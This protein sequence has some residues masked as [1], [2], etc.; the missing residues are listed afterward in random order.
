MAT[1]GILAPRTRSTGG[2]GSNPPAELKQE[3]FGG[4]LMVRAQSAGAVYEPQTDSVAAPPLEID[5]L[6]HITDPIVPGSLIFQWGGITYIDRSGVLFRAVNTTTNA[7]TA[8]GAV[9]YATGVAT[10]QSYPGGEGGVVNR[11]A[12]LTENGGFSTTALTFRTPGAPLRPASLQITV[13]RADNS[14]IVTGTADLN[15][16][17]T[18]G[19]IIHGEVDI[20]SGIVRLRF[21]TNPDDLTGAS[22]VPVIALLVTYNAVIQTSLP[23]SADLLGL[24]PVRLPAD[25]R[26]PIYRDGDVLVIHHATETPVVPSA[27]QT[28]QLERAYQAAIEV[29]DVNGV[30]MRPDQYTAD[31][32]LGL[33]TW[34]DPVLSED[35]E[36]NPLTPPLTLRDRVEHMTVCTE[37]QISG[38]ISFGSPLPWDLSAGETLVSSAVTWGDLQARVH[39]WFTQA[40]WNQGAP[41]WGDTPIGNSTTAQYNQLNYP[42]EITNS[43]AI[44]G[45]WAII[46]TS[47][48]AFNVVEEK[49]G[50][51]TTGATGM[52]CAPINPA[53]GVPYFIIR[54]LGWG[55]GWAA[56][57]AVRF[58]TDACLGPMWVVRTVISGQGAVDDDQFKLQIRGDAD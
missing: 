16:N 24:D 39:R 31:R 6:P 45:K 41:N 46:F 23:M 57:N 30:P 17:V 19:G 5:L 56:G 11:I 51:I 13:I 12:A 27:G 14:I 52:D 48:A 32:E 7:G 49:L 4:T 18:G 3:I 26:V 54:S 35:A 38:A 58:N 10:L 43:G 21:T 20:Q 9:D 36:G 34:A 53:T 44:A 29:V 47:A 25:G 1:Y 50:V 28:V 37:V 8:V 42:V 55:T 33:L 15:G 2:G 22:D 40:A